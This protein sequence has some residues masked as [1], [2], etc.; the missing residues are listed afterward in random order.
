M[1]QFILSSETKAFILTEDKVKTIYINIWNGIKSN[2]YILPRQFLRVTGSSSI[3]RLNSSLTGTDPF[4]L[5]SDE[6]TEVGE[7][8]F[9]TETDTNPFETQLWFLSPSAKMLVFSTI[10]TE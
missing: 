4:K 3:Q 9:G 2:F 5:P 7:L 6:V 1:G 10:L 8:R